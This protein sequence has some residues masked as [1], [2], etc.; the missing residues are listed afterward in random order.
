[1][2]NLNILTGFSLVSQG[3]EKSIRQGSITSSP[4]DPLVAVVAGAIEMVTGQLATAAVVV[5][6][7]A[8]EPEP[9]AFD[10]LYFW[11]DQSVYLQFISGSSNFVIKVK[12]LTPFTTPGFGLM[13]AVSGAT[14]GA[15][16]TGGA[17]PALGTIERVIMGNY[18][19]VAANYNFAAIN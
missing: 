5:L 2:A 18:S 10:Y 19:G 13:H 1:M 12:A 3:N 7:D 8:S 16:I 17:E 15:A 14:G 9:A 4:N 6:Y 11:S